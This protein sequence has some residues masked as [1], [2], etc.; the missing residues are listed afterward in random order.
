MKEFHKAIVD[1]PK[2]LGT[3]TRLFANGLEKPAFEREQ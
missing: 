2:I 1:S 3:P